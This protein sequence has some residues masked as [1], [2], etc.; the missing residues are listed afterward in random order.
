MI[1]YLGTIVA[2]ATAKNNADTAAPFTIPTGTRVLAQPDVSCFI[3]LVK[4][5]GAATTSTGLQLDAA[6]KF[7]FSAGTRLPLVSAITSA[8]TVNL[9]IYAVFPNG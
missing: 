2:T 9:K 1:E 5:G 8:G 7:E 3:A 6:E 4:S